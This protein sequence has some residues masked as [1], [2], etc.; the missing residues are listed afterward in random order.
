MVALTPVFAVIRDS[1]SGFGLFL[2]PK[3]PKTGGAMRHVHL[4]LYRY[5]QE[6]FYRMHG[7]PK[8]QIVIRNRVLFIEK[9]IIFYTAHRTAVAEYYRCS[10]ATGI[11]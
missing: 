9:R 1:S 11:V 2:E 3:M 4:C 5:R 8:T 6:V 10:T 7:N